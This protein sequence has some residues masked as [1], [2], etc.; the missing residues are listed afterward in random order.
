MRIL[1]LSSIYDIK[2]GCFKFSFL[3]TSHN[4]LW[5]S[6]I[7]YYFYWNKNSSKM[8]SWKYDIWTF[9]VC[10]K[11]PKSISRSEYFH[12]PLHSI[13]IKVMKSNARF[14]IFMFPWKF[15]AKKTSATRSSTRTLTRSFNCC[16]SNRGTFHMFSLKKGIFSRLRFHLQ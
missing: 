16:F 10:H 13:Y 1:L 5:N 3:Y 15:M 6:K 4:G 11:L 7:S 2:E 8:I 12:L 9:L 14:I